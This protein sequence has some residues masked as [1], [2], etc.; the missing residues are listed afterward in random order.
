MIMEK[1]RIW[2]FLI[3]LLAVITASQGGCKP[4]RKYNY[5]DPP[6]MYVDRYL[7]AIGNAEMIFSQIYSSNHQYGTFEELLEKHLTLDPNVKDLFKTKYHGCGYWFTIYLS[8]KK[9][10]YCLYA[11]PNKYDDWGHPMTSNGTQ[12]VFF[13]WIGKRGYQ[14]D[15]T[16]FV[17]YFFNTDKFQGKDN[18]PPVGFAFSGKPF[19]SE[20]NEKIWKRNWD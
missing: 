1:L 9:D 10:A 2:F 20:V 8:E 3:L 18:A 12:G 5:P 17:H 15:E 14:S 16:E 13:T 7:F 11:W 6:V 4:Q 19:E